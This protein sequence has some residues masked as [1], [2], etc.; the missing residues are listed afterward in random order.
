MHS[1]HRHILRTTFVT[2]F[3]IK[4]YLPW[5]YIQVIKKCLIQDPYFSCAFTSLPNSHNFP[6]WLHVDSILLHKN[7]LMNASTKFDSLSLPNHHVSTYIHKYSL[8]NTE[9]H[10]QLECPGHLTGL[11]GIKTIRHVSDLFQL[12]FC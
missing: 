12:V 4:G 9:S 8:Y 7:H 1:N 5:F 11:E 3:I 10:L 6:N 2:D